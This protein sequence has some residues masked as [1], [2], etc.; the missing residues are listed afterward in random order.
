MY[1][2]DIGGTNLRIYNA[3]KLIYT[4]LFNGNIN[5]N[6]NL[7]AD[8][9]P[10]LTDYQFDRYTKIGIAGYLTAN[11]Q[12]KNELDA[13]ISGMIDDYKIMSDAQ[14]HAENLI[15]TNQLL[16]SL[17]TGSV[18]SY[19]EDGCFKVIGG[20]G[21]ILGDVGS[22]YH[23]G[24]L[25]IIEYLENCEAGMRLEFMNML[26]VYFGVEGRRILSKT[27]NK[28]KVVLSKLAKEFMDTEEFQWIFE[29]FS[30]QFLNELNRMQ[31]ISEKKEVVIN[32]S[33]VHSKKF[34]KFVLN[35]DRNIIVK[36]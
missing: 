33:I 14:L 35:L 5:T 23:F 26:E 21:Y 12:V 17:G 25:C 1:T 29:K 15:N 3:E 13:V 20:Y 22:G 30:D 11:D 18:G 2:V 27:V 36:K 9:E 31:K 34:Q 24:K 8:L 4:Q 6:E 28:E 7:L 19:F 32:G 16:V 10:I